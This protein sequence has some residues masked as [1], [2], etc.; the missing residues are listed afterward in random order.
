MAA[1]YKPRIPALIGRI[2]RYGFPFIDAVRFQRD[3]VLA[4][5]SPGM[6]V[7]PFCIPAIASLDRLQ[8]HPAVT[9]LVGENGSG[10]STLTEAIAVA[11]G[12][13]GEG[14]SRGAR[15]T[16]RDSVSPLKDYIVLEK[17]ANPRDGF[18][19]RA[20]SFYNLANYIDEAYMSEPFA[21][22]RNYGVN[23]LHNVSHGE[24]FLTFLNNRCGDFGLYIF[25]EPEAALS[26]TR[27][28]SLLV[29]L[30]QLTKGHSQFIIATHSPILLSYPHACI[31]ALSDKGIERVEYRDT[32]QFQVC[33]D[34]LQRHESMLDILLK[35][36]EYQEGRENRGLESVRGPGRG[37]RTR[38]RGLS[39][40]PRPVKPCE[41]LD[42][43]AGEI[44]LYG[45]P[46][47]RALRRSW[48]DAS[49]ADEGE[50]INPA[51]YPFN[52]P[53]IRTLN[54]LEFHPA[55][56]F[57]VGENG[58]GKSTLIEALA[59]KAGFH[60]E[61]GGR[62]E[63]RRAQGTS[64][65]DRFYNRWVGE[66][67]A[68]LSRW[69]TLERGASH[70]LDG[71]FLRGESFHAMATQN[72]EDGGGGL[73]KYGVSSLHEV[74]HGESFMAAFLHRCSPAGLYLLDEPES[75]LSPTRQLSLIVRLHQLTRGHAQFVIATHSPILLSYP[76]AW[77]YVL[78]DHGFQRQNY[79][80]TEHYKV[81]RNFLS[82]HEHMLQHLLQNEKTEELL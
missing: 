67:Q 79:M 60:L 74:S 6:D 57:L 29:R 18:F 38:R 22:L 50:L 47:L 32:E 17:R 66:D 30:H 71:F 65:E 63:I 20:E 62:D 40:S 5:D 77:I 81:Y 12:L 28:M 39:A 56:T 16:T 68:R 15:F 46:F 7:Y 59:H 55:V 69:L 24:S 11:C 48:P 4:P 34:F 9:F 43:L 72:E 44:P 54:R 49:I 76:H 14:G 27:Q 3:K 21:K 10:K 37:K 23:S 8:L 45:Y 33:S 31:Y 58:S 70:F 64:R 26:P 41:R 13:N 75:A 1:S 2:P 61:G 78:G 80:D 42:C 25:D 73:S 19:L 36:D 35:D 52:I 51:Q 82:Q 53:A